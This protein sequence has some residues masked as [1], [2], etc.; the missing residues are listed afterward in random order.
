MRHESAMLVGAEFDAS[1]TSVVY[2][3]DGGKITAF[4]V[5]HNLHG[6]VGYRVDLAGLSMV[7]SGDTHPCWPLVHAAQ[8]TDL[9]IHECFPRRQPWP[10]FPAAPSSGSR[11]SP[12][13]IFCPRPP[14]GALA[15]V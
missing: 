13:R 10:L 12:P 1:I 7:F 8:G 11:P 4:S 9:R 2:E 3:Q 15:R 5:I 6:A 14:A